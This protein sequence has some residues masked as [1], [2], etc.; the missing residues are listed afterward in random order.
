MHS[1]GSGFVLNSKQVHNILAPNC[2]DCCVLID[3]APV[4]VIHN[5]LLKYNYSAKRNV[6]WATML[7]GRKVSCNIMAVAL[8]VVILFD[9]FNY[10]LLHALNC[11]NYVHK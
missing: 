10:A 4:F 6:K 1:K 7:F 8:F 5:F 9:A 11:P 2:I 3:I